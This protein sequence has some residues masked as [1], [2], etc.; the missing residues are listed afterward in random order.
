MINDKEKKINTMWI[1]FLT[2]SY[3]NKL[4][5]KVILERVHLQDN[6]YP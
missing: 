4:S 2:S 5:K 1:L 6:L 3:Q